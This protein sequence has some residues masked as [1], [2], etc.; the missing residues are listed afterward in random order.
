MHHEQDGLTE[1]RTVGTY[2]HV[3]AESGAFD[4][5]VDAL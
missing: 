4:A 2:C 1:Y 3:H 5:F